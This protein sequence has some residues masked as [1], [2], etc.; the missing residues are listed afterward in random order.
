MYVHYQRKAAC[1]SV[2]IA[3]GRLNKLCDYNI[4]KFRNIFN[5][6][7]LR[8]RQRKS[9]FHNRQVIDSL[10]EEIL[11]YKKGPFLRSELGEYL[12]G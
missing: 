9:G 2:V 4:K 3:I 7:P 11:V 5:F 1:S 12:Q 10:A 8:T 6:S